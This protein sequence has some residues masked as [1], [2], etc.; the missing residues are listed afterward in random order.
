MDAVFL[1]IDYIHKS[2]LID[3]F[4]NLFSVL[5]LYLPNNRNRR[6][7]KTVAAAGAEEA[8]VCS[9]E[10]HITNAIANLIAFAAIGIH[11]LTAVEDLHSATC[12][13]DYQI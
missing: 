12:V 6:L 7:L 9:S 13:V 2:F 8:M 5:V 10:I 11:P 3:R 4:Q 1:T